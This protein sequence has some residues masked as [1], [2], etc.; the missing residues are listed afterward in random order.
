MLHLLL[1]VSHHACTYCLHSSSVPCGCTSCQ[2]IAAAM[3]LPSSGPAFCRP[4]VDMTCFPSISA[5]HCQQSCSPN[6]SAAASKLAAMSLLLMLAASASWL[7]LSSDMVSSP[8]EL[9]ESTP[10]GA[11][12]LLVSTGASMNPSLQCCLS[13]RIMLPMVTLRL[14][15]ALLASPEADSWCAMLSSSGATSCSSTVISPSLARHLSDSRTMCVDTGAGLPLAAMVVHC[16]S[17]S[18]RA[19]SRKYRLS[20]LSSVTPWDTRIASAA[21]MHSTQCSEKLA[22]SRD[23]AFAGGANTTGNRDSCSSSLTDAS[24]LGPLNMPSSSVPT[25]SLLIFCASAMRTCSLAAA[26]VS[27]ASSSNPNL[28][29]KRTARSTRRGSSRKVSRGGRGVR[30]RPARRSARPRPVRSST[31]PWLML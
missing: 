24:G 28:V 27:A 13:L 12:C 14:S 1:W 2:S 17:G 15:G 26:A 19:A 4:S 23:C 8:A 11:A 10:R 31:H 7:L 9:A 16:L 22:S 21:A 18:S 25:R 6:A 5:F 20:S 29:P 30:M 3:I